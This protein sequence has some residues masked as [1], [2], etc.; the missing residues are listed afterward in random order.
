VHFWLLKSAACRP[1]G[2]AVLC[3]GS[4]TLLTTP[5]S[6]PIPSA[7]EATADQ[8][9]RCNFAYNRS[10]DSPNVLRVL[11][12]NPFLSEHDGAGSMLVL[13]NHNSGTSM[14]TR[15]LMLMGAF[16]GNLEGARPPAAATRWPCAAR[17][18]M[19]RR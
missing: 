5:T 1:S 16:Q 17:C 13:G 3:A 19:C 7:A 18:Q 9:W 14:L 11:Y 10:F 4:S 12:G 8:L 2:A 6:S 15:L